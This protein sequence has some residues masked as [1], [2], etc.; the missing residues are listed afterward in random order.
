[1]H[2]HLDGSCSLTSYESWPR[3]AALPRTVLEE[4][5]GSKMSVFDASPFDR[6]SPSRV[7]IWDFGNLGA[8]RRVRMILSAVRYE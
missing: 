1:M 2:A 3:L 4:L 6:L 5:P 7:P 8:T